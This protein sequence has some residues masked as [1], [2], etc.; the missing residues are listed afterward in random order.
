MYNILV[1]VLRTV[2]ETSVTENFIVLNDFQLR[3]E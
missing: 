1:Y 2:I 3:G